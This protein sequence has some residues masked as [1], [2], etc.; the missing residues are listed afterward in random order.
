MLSATR[1]GTPGPS[2]SLAADRPE[3]PALPEAV[4]GTDGSVAG[5]AGTTQPLLPST[6]AE[7]TQP[8]P[9]DDPAATTQPTSPAKDA[10][11]PPNGEGGSASQDATQRLAPVGN[12]GAKSRSSK[13]STREGK[14]RP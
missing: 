3:Q 14:G 2:G 13:P 7:T 1:P 9:A 12:S 10:A 4:D 6:T 8:T 5:D 11:G